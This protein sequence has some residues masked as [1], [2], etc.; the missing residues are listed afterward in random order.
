[1]SNEKRF[2][3]F[4]V[5]YIFLLIGN[6]L[7]GTKTIRHLTRTRGLMVGF[8]LIVYIKFIVFFVAVFNIIKMGYLVW[9]GLVGNVTSPI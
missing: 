7:T 4:Y 6:E 1:M 8:F 2:I 3:Y 5:L 9:L